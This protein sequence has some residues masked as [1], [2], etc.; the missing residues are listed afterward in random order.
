[1][2]VAGAVVLVTGASSGIGRATALAFDAAGA[3]VAMAA[4]RRERLEENA[5]RMR[6]PLVVPTDLSDMAQAT[7][8]VERTLEHYG[9]LDV[10]INN[11]A[12]I[13]MARADGIRTPLV[14]RVLE[15]NVLGPMVATNRAVR[16]MRRQGAGHVINI[17][18]PGFI[19]GV[20]LMGAYS[21]SK[22]AL[23]G[24]TRCLQAEW[25]GTEIFVS[26][27]LPGYVDT[28]SEADSD[29]GV[30]GPGLFQDPEQSFVARWFTNKQPAEEVAAD[31]VR[32]VRRPRLIMYSSPSI[33]VLLW[34]ARFSRMRQAMGAGMARACRKRLNITAFSD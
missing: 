13:P 1:M 19:L 32:C 33:R 29:F 31:L 25:A 17:G 23:S 15:T 34:L 21:M 7:A 22:A 30:L 20:P 14:Q 8:M 5:A 27:Y 24:W 4:R 6:D 18:S 9:R 12:M 2:E 16:A 3:R 10:L 26:E 28:E 11:A